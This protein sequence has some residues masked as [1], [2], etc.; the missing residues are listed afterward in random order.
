[1][2]FLIIQFLLYF[3]NFKLLNA[4]KTNAIVVRTRDNVGIYIKSKIKLL[5]SFSL[6]SDDAVN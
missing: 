3:N 5:S 2:F 4:L 6:Q 1:M